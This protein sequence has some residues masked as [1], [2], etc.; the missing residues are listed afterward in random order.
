ML[1]R[2]PLAIVA[3]SAVDSRKNKASS[4]ATASPQGASTATPPQ[5]KSGVPRGFRSEL[6]NKIKTNPWKTLG[7]VLLAT[8]FPVGT[9]IAGVI[10]TGVVAKSAR[11]VSVNKKAAIP[12]AKPIPSP[13]SRPRPRYATPIKS[14]AP[15]PAVGKSTGQSKSR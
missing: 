4:K 9:A 2:L 6:M 3:K 1:E 7:T 12:I 13:I 11:D 15:P 10:A 8:A 5:V 14:P